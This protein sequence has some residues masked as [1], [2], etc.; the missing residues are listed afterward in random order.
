MKG[1][2]LMDVHWKLLCV[3]QI[4]WKNVWHS[5]LLGAKRNIFITRFVLKVIDS[6]QAF[7]L[8]GKTRQVV[9]F[10]CLIVYPLSKGILY[11]QEGYGT[12]CAVV[13]K[14]WAWQFYQCTNFVFIVLKVH[15]TVS[16]QLHIWYHSLPVHKEFPGFSSWDILLWK[17]SIQL[18]RI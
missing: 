3:S 4:D 10:M 5:N 11:T 1:P 16:W 8:I 17:L 13:N 7:L 15:S 18:I 14:L 2:S 9:F 12:I 6:S